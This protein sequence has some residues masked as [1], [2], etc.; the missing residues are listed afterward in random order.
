VITI[1]DPIIGNHLVHC[2]NDHLVDRVN[3]CLVDCAN[4]HLVHLLVIQQ[5]TINDP[6]I[7]L[8][9]QTLQGL[10]N[11]IHMYNFVKG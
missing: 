10:K 6:L 9:A 5:S 7:T 2:T 1:T 4:D 8:V 3:D 11:C